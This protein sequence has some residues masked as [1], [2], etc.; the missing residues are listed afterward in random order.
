MKFKVRVDVVKTYDIIVEAGLGGEAW[1]LIRKTEID[2]IE[3]NGTLIS[4]TITMDIP[5]EKVED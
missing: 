2:S 3:S 1:S 5:P 4:S